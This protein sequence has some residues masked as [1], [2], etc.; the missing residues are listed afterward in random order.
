M[1]KQKTNRQIVHLRKLGKHYNKTAAPFERA[2]DKESED[3][4]ATS[5]PF[6]HSRFPCSDSLQTSVMDALSLVATNTYP[7]HEVLSMIIGRTDSTTP[8]LSH[9]RQ[10]S[11]SP[12]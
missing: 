2:L 3:T 1:R 10:Q 6:E 11:P 12:V 4:P 5:R 8:M 7:S 9:Q